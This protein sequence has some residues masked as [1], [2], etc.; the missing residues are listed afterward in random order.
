MFS[1]IDAFVLCLKGHHLLSVVVV[2]HRSV[3]HTL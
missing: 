3:V 2:Y 1:F